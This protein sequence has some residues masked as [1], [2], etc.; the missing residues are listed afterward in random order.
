MSHASTPKA[1]SGGG[2]ISQAIKGTISDA[3]G[4]RAAQ[5]FSGGEGAPGTSNDSEAQTNW[6]ETFN[7]NLPE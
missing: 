7:Q 4:G 1:K 3:I 5:D 6:G 2:P